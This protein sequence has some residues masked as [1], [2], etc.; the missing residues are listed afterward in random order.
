MKRYKCHKEVSAMRVDRIDDRGVIGA[1]L[2]SVGGTEEAPVDIDSVAV[3]VAFIE[4]HKPTAPG[5]FVRYDDGYES[6]SPAGAFEDGYSEV[7]PKR[8]AS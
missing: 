8:A 2:V 6:F 4:R 7:K 5:Y 3:S 1:A